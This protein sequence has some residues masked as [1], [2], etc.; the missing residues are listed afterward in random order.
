MQTEYIQ[1]YKL[2]H[3]YKTKINIGISYT[4][5][6]N[7]SLRDSYEYWNRLWGPRAVT[8]FLFLS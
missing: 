6:Q 2:R 4:R 7:N 8:T 1:I 5:S 3:E